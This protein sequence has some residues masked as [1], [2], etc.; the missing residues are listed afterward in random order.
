MPFH[1]GVLRRC[2]NVCEY[3]L[4]IRQ[5][6]Y[7]LLD[8][9]ENLYKWT[10]GAKEGSQ[11]IYFFY[12]PYLLTFLFF[13][14][15]LTFLPTYFFVFSFLLLLLTFPFNHHLSFSFSASS[16]LSFY[17][18]SSLT[19]IFP[20]FASFPLFT[21]HY[22]FPPPL[23]VRSFLPLPLNFLLYLMTSSMHPFSL[24]FSSS[25]FPLFTPNYP[26]PPALPVRSSFLPASSISSS[27]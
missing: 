2:S 15:F 21:P 22:L 23:P 14:L 25:P 24:L 18:S 9:G 20:P 16:L 26:F 17:L 10:E 3:W 5:D 11:F 7:D 13:P 19:T 27:T 8:L 1:I 6:Q 12:S 4:Y